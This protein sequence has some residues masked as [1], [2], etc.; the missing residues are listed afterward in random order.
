LILDFGWLE[1]FDEGFEAATTARGSGPGGGEASGKMVEQRG[2]GT[3]CR[4]PDANARRAL[5]HARG[6]LDQAQPQGVE[7]GTG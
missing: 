6:D 5:D 1:S 4:Q 3:P 2:V 7:L